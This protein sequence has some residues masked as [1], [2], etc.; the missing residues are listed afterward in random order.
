MTFCSGAV[1]ATLRSAANCDSNAPLLIT[2]YTAG[3]LHPH[4]T[5]RARVTSL[6]FS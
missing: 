2:V 5:F 1:A 6:L 3:L 4:H